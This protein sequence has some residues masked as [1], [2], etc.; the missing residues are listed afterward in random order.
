MT[1]SK[2]TNNLLETIKPL[3]LSPLENSNSKNSFDPKQIFAI[4]F[5]I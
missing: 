5:Y 2:S 3:I 4:E 1:V